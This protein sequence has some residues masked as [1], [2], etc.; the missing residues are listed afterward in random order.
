[1]SL[2]RCFSRIS[3]RK[4]YMMLYLHWFFIILAIYLENLLELLRESMSFSRNPYS[5][6]VTVIYSNF[7]RVYWRF[8]SEI[9]NFFFNLLD[10]CQDKSLL[11]F[12]R[13]ISKKYWRKSWSNLRKNPKNISGKVFDWISENVG[14]R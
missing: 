10:P 14:S 12:L 6:R 5:S 4:T 1:M 2:V 11:I 13:N 9:P 3:F 8:S 7:I